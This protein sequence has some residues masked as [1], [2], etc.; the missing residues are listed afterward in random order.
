MDNEDTAKPVV[1]TEVEEKPKKSRGRPKGTTDTKKLK[2]KLKPSPK[3]A[4]EDFKREYEDLGLIA[5][6]GVDEFTEELI[7]YLWS[8]VSKDFIVTDPV[9]QRAA[10]LNRSIGGL[11][12]SLYRFQIINHVNW[13]E[14]GMFPVVVVAEEYWEEINKLPNPD[15]VELVCLSLWEKK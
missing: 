3:N 2:V 7:R 12:Y 8:D 14:G 6:Y 11:P 13:I 4:K 1:T 5:I 9:E 15:G 10:T